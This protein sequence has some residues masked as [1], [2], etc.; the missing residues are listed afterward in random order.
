MDLFDII[1][2]AG[3]APVNILHGTDWWTDCDDVAALRL[4]LRAHRVG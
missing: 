3:R 2:S 4:L 1:K